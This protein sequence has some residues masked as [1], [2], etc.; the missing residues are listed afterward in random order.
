MPKV[1]A[2][3][4]RLAIL[5]AGPVRDLRRIFAGREGAG[6]ESAMAAETKATVRGFLDPETARRVGA[7]SK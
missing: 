2:L 7:F 4:K 1:I 6:L 3:A 5:P